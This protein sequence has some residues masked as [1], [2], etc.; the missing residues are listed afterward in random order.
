MSAVEQEATAERKRSRINLSTVTP[1]NID[2]WWKPRIARGKVHLLQGDPGVAK[3]YVTLA[4]AACNSRGGGINPDGTIA[5]G[6]P[7]RTLLMAVE[8][9]L[10]DT[11]VPRLIKC[12]ADLS[13]IETFGIDNQF[14]LD[15]DGIAL[16][17]QHLADVQPSL[18]II[19]PVTFFLGG[20]I[21]MHRANEVR[22]PLAALGRLAERYGCAIIL[23]IHMNKGQAKS[24]Y[25]AL[26]SI[27]FTAVVRS[28]LMAGRVEDAPERGRALFHIKSNIGV[29]A[30]PVG[31]DVVE[32]PEDDVGRFVWLPT[33][34]LT[35]R[36]VEGRVPGPK[37]VKQQEAVRWLK[38]VLADGPQPGCAVKT[39]AAEAGISERTLKAVSAWLVLKEQIPESRDYTWTLNPVGMSLAAT[40]A[41]ATLPLVEHWA[42]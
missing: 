32:D 27:D 38:A 19:D 13:M 7:G 15:P 40:A 8:D 11:T 1:R 18:V 9:G 36:E 31:Y 29:E 24:L 39:A 5:Q 17:E 22:Q 6:T 23:V 41:T 12:G 34:D 35:I 30:P 25:R 28:M 20:R 10:E 3:S 4:L 37:P 16:L 42:G 21:D 33:T 26:G 14:V 2:W